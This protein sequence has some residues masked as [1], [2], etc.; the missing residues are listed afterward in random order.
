[1]IW[2]AARSSIT[3]G[4]PFCFNL[5][6]YQISADAYRAGGK[7]ARYEIEQ[8]PTVAQFLHITNAVSGNDSNIALEAL[9]SLGCSRCIPGSMSAQSPC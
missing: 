3:A 8:T 9:G 7:A 2:P 5:N 4:R 1:M 6:V